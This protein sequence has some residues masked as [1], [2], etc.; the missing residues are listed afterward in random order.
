MDPFKKAPQ[1]LTTVHNATKE[2]NRRR[3][4]RPPELQ[5][6]AAATLVAAGDPF[7]LSEDERNDLAGEIAQFCVPIESKWVGR[8]K[9]HHID[10]AF[11]NLKENVI[12]KLRQH[13][14]MASGE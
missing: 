14:V 13:G 9:R 12:R 4:K 1:N 10:M 8:I 3:T 11:D 2:M 5:I 6:H 7:A